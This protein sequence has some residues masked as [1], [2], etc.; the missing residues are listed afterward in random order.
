MTQELS[1]SQKTIDEV[2]K[3]WP[4]TAVVFKRHNMAC[5]GCDVAH[6]YTIADAAAVYKLPIDEFISELE[7]AI[8]NL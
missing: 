2:L 1:L 4:E 7:V 6:L 8:G 3:N 5:I